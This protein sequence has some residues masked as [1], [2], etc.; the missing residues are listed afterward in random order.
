MNFATNAGYIKVNGIKLTQNG[1]EV[2]SFAGL[3]QGQEAKVT[4]SYDKTSKE[5]KIIKLIY[6][7]YNG[8]ELVKSVVKTITISAQDRTGTKEDTVTVEDLTGI[9]GVSVM[10]WEDFTSIKPLCQDIKL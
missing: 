1:S 2:T 7:Y 6:A 3:A 10:L 8:T 9:T 5:E 4:V